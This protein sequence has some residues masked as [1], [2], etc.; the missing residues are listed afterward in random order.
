MIFP[1]FTGILLTPTSFPQVRFLARFRCKWGSEYR[2]SLE[3]GPALTAVPR[4]NEM[5][6]TVGVVPACAIRARWVGGNM[7]GADDCL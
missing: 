3:K 6:V 5:S 4:I 1:E 7:S 2:R